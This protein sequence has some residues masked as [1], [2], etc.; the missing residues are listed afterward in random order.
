MAS[1]RPSGRAGQTRAALQG[2]LHPQ[3]E[4]SPPPGRV[5]GG[6]QGERRL[7]LR[8]LLPWA[9]VG[10]V[11]QAKLGFQSDTTLC[12]RYNACKVWYRCTSVDIAVKTRPNGHRPLGQPGHT[13][14][15]AAKTEPTTGALPSAPAPPGRGGAPKTPSRRPLPRPHKGLLPQPI[16]Q[17]GPTR[18][19]ECALGQVSPH[20]G[21]LLTCPNAPFPAPMRGTAAAPA[22]NGPRPTSAPNRPHP[23]LADNTQPPT[24][25][26]RPLFETHPTPPNHVPTCAQASLLLWL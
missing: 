17:S 24:P 2:I 8:S 16:R 25:P 12:K 18:A 7:V 6:A 1:T 13:G 9:G 5:W 20:W 10:A 14:G 15:I 19:G 23:R 22:D 21:R 4:A 11:L 26:P 3:R